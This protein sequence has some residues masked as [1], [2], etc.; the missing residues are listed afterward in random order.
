MVAWPLGSGSGEAT[1][2]GHETMKIKRDRVKL[3]EVDAS[4]DSW[5]SGRMTT[6]EGMDVGR[7]GIARSVGGFGHGALEKA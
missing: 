3:R 1:A 4:S 7:R 2:A 6:E 5:G